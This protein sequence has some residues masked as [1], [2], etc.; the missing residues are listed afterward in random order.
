MDPKKRVFFVILYRPPPSQENEYKTSAFL[1][2]FDEFLPEIIMSSP[3][4]TRSVW[5]L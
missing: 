3:W 4:E 1:Q 2:E 5:R